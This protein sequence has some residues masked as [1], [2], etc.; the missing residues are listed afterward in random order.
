MTFKDYHCC[1]V[2]YRT[3]LSNTGTPVRLTAGLVSEL[4]IPVNIFNNGDDA[5]AAQLSFTLPIG[6]LEFVRVDP[7]NVSTDIATDGFL[8]VM[9]TCTPG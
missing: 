9:H 5:Y 7:R 6:L 8:S 3:E 2:H 1:P 4:A